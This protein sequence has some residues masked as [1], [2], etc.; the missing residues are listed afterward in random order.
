MLWALIIRRNAESTGKKLFS[1]W[2]NILLYNFC[3]HMHIFTLDVFGFQI[4]PTWYGLM[5]ALGFVLCHFFF[6][7]YSKH[8]KK[9]LE[10]IG[11][12]I[13]LWVI[14][15]GRIGYILFYNLSYFI[16]NPLSIWKIWE[17]GMSFHGGF[18]G[19]LIAVF[20]YQKGQKKPFFELMDLL[21]IC[22]PIALGLWRIGNHINRELLGFSP[23][24]G[25]FKIL[26]NG[27]YHFPSTLLEM[28]LEWIFLFI[29]LYGLFIFY[30]R[31]KIGTGY[32][33]SI[34][35]I[36]YGIGRLISEFFRLPDMHIGYLFGTS[37]ITLGMIYTIP[38]LI[39]GIVLL[40]RS[41]KMLMNAHL[42]LSGK[43]ISE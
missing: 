40:Q 18:L 20:L 22:T 13:F 26:A 10:D 11:I 8:S 6:K 25:P 1:K 41:K 37:V 16:E 35:L 19:V 30:K 21:A 7:R 14:L 3:I 24:T 15:G 17:W 42:W 5:Y 33:S 27:S 9:E 2:K 39:W 32:Y 36:G 43:Q 31:E 34:F 28:F 12:W 4:G 23:Y 29:I 38:F